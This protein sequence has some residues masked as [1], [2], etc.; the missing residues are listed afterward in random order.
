MVSEAVEEIKNKISSLSDW[1]KVMNM[2]K[3]SENT[4]KLSLELKKSFSS[5]NLPYEPG[6][7]F[8]HNLGFRIARHHMMQKGNIMMPMETF[9]DLLN[10]KVS[11]V[12]DLILKEKDPEATLERMVSFKKPNNFQPKL[13][14]MLENINQEI[15]YLKNDAKSLIKKLIKK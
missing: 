11:M 2:F 1:S 3:E 14:N 15:Q 7:E 6:K 8:F 9:V 13:I 12:E 5:K 4:R 10:N